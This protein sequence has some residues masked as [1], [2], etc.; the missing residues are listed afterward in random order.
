MNQ[1]QKNDN[2]LDIRASMIYQFLITMTKKK[3]FLRKWFNYLYKNLFAALQKFQKFTYL[4]LN[5]KTFLYL[6][7]NNN[8]Y[9]EY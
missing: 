2:H 3:S 8:R 7:L 9:T 4:N 1:N 6:W 5:L